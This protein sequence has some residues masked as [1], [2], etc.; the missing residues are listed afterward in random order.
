MK[1][2]VAYN[3]HTR[4]MTLRNDVMA[5]LGHERTDLEA[6]G[7]AATLTLFRPGTSL[8]QLIKSVKIV[9]DDL[10]LRKELAENEN[11]LEEDVR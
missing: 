2:K 4:S 11:K 1:T 5:L 6:L 8:E 3:P 7:N 10:R 9:L